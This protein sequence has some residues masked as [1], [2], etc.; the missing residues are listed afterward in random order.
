MAATTQVRLLVRSFVRA[1]W[2]TH[3]D[4]GKKEAL[5]EPCLAQV[6]MCI[7]PRPGI[8]LGTFRSSV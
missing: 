3:N 4:L 8:E 5:R 7:M 1:S 2:P 6:A